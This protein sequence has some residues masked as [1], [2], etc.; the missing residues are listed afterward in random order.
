MQTLTAKHWTEVRDPYGRIG[1][2]SEGTE[3]DGNPIDRPTVSTNLDCWELSET[4]PL[5]KEHK[6]AGPR[7]WHICSRELP[8]LASV[9]EDVPNPVE[10]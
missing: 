4:E 9:G 2:K 7:P 3:G 8:S 5:I 10:A 6:E 1:G